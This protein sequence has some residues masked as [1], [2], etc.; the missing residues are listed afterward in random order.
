MIM[1]P[2]PTIAIIEN[3]IDITGSLKS[4]IASIDGLR[5]NF[6]FV[7][8]L[9]SGSRA[10]AYIQ[11]SG[12]PIHEL[13]MRELSRGLIA[14]IIYLPYLLANSIR[15]FRLTRKLALNG[16]IVNDFYNL[17]P[18]VYKLFWG[19]LEYACYVRFRP[20]RFPAVLV[21]L[22]FGFH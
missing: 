18:A 11:E 3:S 4:A 14:W 17:I 15:L 5:D 7:F 2:K 10:T 16:I 19:K 20:S 22:W 13:P 21:K 12:Y 1:Q 6:N 8:I 9:P